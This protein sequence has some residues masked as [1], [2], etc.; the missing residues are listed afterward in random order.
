MKFENMNIGT[1]L[2]LGFASAFLLLVLAMVTLIYRQSVT[3]SETEKLTGPVIEKLNLA[4]GIKEGNL[5][6][7]INF[8]ALL[9][10]RDKA[11]QAAIQADIKEVNRRNNENVERIAKLATDADSQA[12]LKAIEAARNE[13][14]AARNA[15]VKLAVDEGRNDDALREWNAKAAPKLA[16][17]R[18]A[19][20][21]LK[22]IQTE[23]VDKTGNEIEAIYYS[24]RNQALAICVIAAILF[25]VLARFTATSITRPIASALTTAQAIAQGRLDN[26]IRISRHDETGQLLAAM[27]IMQDNLAEIVKSVRSSAEAV[28][29]A[30][31]EVAGATLDLSQR[32]EEHASSLEETAASMEELTSA[33]K[34]NSSNAKQANQLAQGATTKASLGGETVQLLVGSMHDITQSSKRISEIISV[35]DGIAFQTNILALN[36]AVEA[37]RAGEQGRGFAVVAAEVRSL[38]QRSAL[39]A[40]EIKELIVNSVH[41]VET[42]AIQVD[43]AGAAINQL[44]E[45]VKRVSELMSDIANASAE[46]G[47]GIEQVNVAV[48]Q[49]DTV[50]QQNAAVV[51]ESAAAAE[52]MRIQASSLLDLVSKFTLAGDD[53]SGS[54][55]TRRV[56][57]MTQHPGSMAKLSP[58]PRVRLTKAAGAGR[59][60][61][62][63]VA[64]T[65]GGTWEE[66]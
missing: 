27:K 16:P 25:V 5:E 48:T 47:Q 12:A 65:D 49:M 21:N 23:T 30:S 44:V 51:E 60:K 39:S 43:Q 64:A 66:F 7:V 13:F 41:Q 40:K 38:A 2:A 37:A 57:T 11:K 22:R 36:A 63:L 29:S 31:N 58:S 53:S 20:D 14:V 59:S 4:T 45:D 3:F 55:A 56:K 28:A 10:E 17:Y 34:E 46:Q 15:A 61:V 19:V 26:D 6:N 32:T 54:R 1:R 18:A 42:G 50:V 8:I 9:N 52:S 24:S 62:A 33:V 35:I